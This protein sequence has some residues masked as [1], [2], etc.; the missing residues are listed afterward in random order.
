MSRKGGK[1]RNKFQVA[2]DRFR[3]TELYLKG[4]TQ[5]QIANQ[6]DMHQTMVSK[7]LAEIR[8]QWQDEYLGKFHLKQCYELGCLDE[9]EERQMRKFERS[10]NSGDGDPVY[11]DSALRCIEKRLKIIGAL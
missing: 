4:L 9:E 11:L 6:L 3:I 1:Q 2:F 7:E 5:T 10:K 8:R